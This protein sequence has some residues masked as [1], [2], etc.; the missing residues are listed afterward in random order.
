MQSCFFFFSVETLSIFKHNPETDF[1]ILI[2]IVFVG[3]Q[4]V[5]HSLVFNV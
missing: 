1:E 2:Q 3:R 5:I 4:L